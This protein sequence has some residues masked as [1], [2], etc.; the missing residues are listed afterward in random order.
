MTTALISTNPVA[1]LANYPDNP[2]RI[3]L[4]GPVQVFC[5]AVPWTSPDGGYRLVQVAPFV[6][7]SGQVT[8]GAPSYSVDASG[9][10]T[11]TYATVAAPPPTVTSLQFMQL[12]TTAEALA[13]ETAA[14]TDPQTALFMHEMAAAGDIPLGSAS[15][16]A[17]L[18]YLVGKSLITS[19]RS[20]QISAGT[21]PAS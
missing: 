15:V 7:P 2:Q 18:A 12:F 6:V 10:V 17:G 8:T 3:D 14:E 20:A 13:I 16:A 5:P 1:V 11:E 19:A 9:N 4:P 21:A